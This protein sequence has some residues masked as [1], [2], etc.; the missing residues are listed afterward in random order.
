[1]GGVNGALGGLIIG[2]PFG[3]LV[4]AGGAVGGTRGAVPAG[5]VGG[6]M[7]VL[8]VP[9][10]YGLCGLVGGAI[11]GVI[12]NIAAHFAGGLKFKTG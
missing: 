11:G 10:F 5:I 8:L 12:Y 4:M 3:I 2:I 1:M 7:A 6:L 9:L